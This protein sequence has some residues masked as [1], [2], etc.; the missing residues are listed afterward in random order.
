M[1]FPSYLLA[2]LSRDWY[3]LEKSK[4]VKAFRCG[5]FDDCIE[6]AESSQGMPI[7]KRE[8]Y[9][10]REDAI[11][12]ALELE[13]QL[14]KKQGKLG[15]ASDQTNRRSSNGVKKGL[16]TSPEPLGN[17]NEKHSNLESHTSCPGNPFPSD[18]ANTGVLLSGEEDHSET[19]PHM[20]GLLDLGHKIAPLKGKLASSVDLN[21]SDKLTV[22]DSSLALARSRL[23]LGST[24]HTNG[25][26]L[27]TRENGQM[28][29]K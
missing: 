1:L 7:K 2:Y 25:K 24:I 17:D 29:V 3:N 9:A 11:L 18:S 26:T 28:W 21:V 27:K 4:R 8:K 15:I 20:K 6:R 13:R 14:L 12:H 10:R 19:I 5:E 16:L 23:C 22:D